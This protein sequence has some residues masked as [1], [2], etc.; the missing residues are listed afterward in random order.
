MQPPPKETSRSRA[1]RKDRSR[2]A[3]V[4]KKARCLATTSAISGMARL[5]QHTIDRLV[6]KVYMY[7]HRWLEEVRMS[8][9]LTWDRVVPR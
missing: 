6:N 2:V 1:R 8:W 7:I 4:R 3:P 5:S 9:P